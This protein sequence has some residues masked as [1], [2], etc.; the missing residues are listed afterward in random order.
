MNGPPHGATRVLVVCTTFPVPTETFVRRD[1]E[2]AAAC[3]VEITVASCWGG[4]GEVGGRPV[5]T[6]RPFDRLALLWRVPWALVVSAEA[7]RI[8]RLCTAWPP[9]RLSFLENLA[10]FACGLTLAARGVRADVV[11]A[12]WAGGPAAAALAFRALTGTPYSTGAHAYD[13]FQYGG[14]WLLGP[15]LASAARV[16]TSTEAAAR[17]A[18]AAGAR[19]GALRTIRRSLPRPPAWRAPRRGPVTLR[20]LSVARLIPKKGHAAQIAILRELARAGV[21]FEARWAGEGPLRGALERALRGAGLAERVR[22]LGHVSEEDVRGLLAWADALVFTGVTAPDGD[23]DGL[24]NAVLE[25]M[26]A[27]VVVFATRADGLC[28]AV[29]DGDTGCVFNPDEPVVW[30][31][32]LAAFAA[33]PSAWSS[34]AERARR[35]VERETAP[36]SVGAALAQM[37][38]EAAAER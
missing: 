34:L 18:A 35:W 15:K 36:E 29:R 25:A 30:A 19:A 31:E 4:G 11:H 32:R 3:G 28:E 17:K 1:L 24:P 9:S 13:L 7:R 14:D 33:D 2:S 10:G 12:A 38:R 27:G 37:F 6:M 20:L 16:H 21:P 5:L 8:A 22:L 23:R 26:A